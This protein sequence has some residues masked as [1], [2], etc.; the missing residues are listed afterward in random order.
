[1]GQMRRSQPGLSCYIFLHAQVLGG[2]GASPTRSLRDRR[3]ISRQ[4]LVSNIEGSRA[5]KHEKLGVHSFERVVRP[6][7][8]FRRHRSVATFVVTL[9]PAHLQ[10]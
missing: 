10:P 4:S 3:S 1:M 5:L 8:V 9:K 6:V 2:L 7:A